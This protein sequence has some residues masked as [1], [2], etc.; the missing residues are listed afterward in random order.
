[1]ARAGGRGF[2]CGSAL[3]GQRGPAPAQPGYQARAGSPGQLPPS[4]LTVPPDAIMQLH[5]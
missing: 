4:G 5:C 2:R 1:M 3:P